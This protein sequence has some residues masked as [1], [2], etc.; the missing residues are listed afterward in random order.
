MN[1]ILSNV[2]RRLK[3]AGITSLE[4]FHCDHFEPWADNTGNGNYIPNYQIEP[5]EL[6]RDQKSL[7]D[8]FVEQSDHAWYAKKLTLFY[9]PALLALHQDE[10][11]TNSLLKNDKD[12]IGFV[13]YDEEIQRLMTNALSKVSASTHEIQLHLHHETFTNSD[14]SKSAITHQWLESQSSPVQD[15]DRLRLALDY[16]KSLIKNDLGVELK[17]W[18]FVHG[19]WALN[20]SDKSVCRISNELSILKKAGCFGD[21]TFPAGRKNTNPT[22][23]LLPFTCVPKNVDKCYDSINSSPLVISDNM[24]RT[25]DRFF[26][27]NSVLQHRGA[28]L[29]YYSKIVKD[30]FSDPEEAVFNWITQSPVFNNKIYLKTHAH[31]LATQ[32]WKGTENLVIPH[33]WP[34]IKESFNLMFDCLSSSG[35]D[36]N[37]RTVSEVYSDLM[38][39]D[40]VINNT[41]N[42]NNY[43]LADKPKL[44]QGESQISER[45]LKVEMDSLWKEK[46]VN[47]G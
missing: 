36:V 24:S 27:W 30:N 33:Q 37:C 47:L 19:K 45:V 10:D 23:I 1:T 16:T 8:S 2:A 20:A 35:I 40:V 11:S 13:Q 46:R 42:L 43:E 28:S 5:N 34:A 9:Q 39:A 26:I 18:A 14:Q 17:K 41:T 7:V 6:C 44:R 15:E 31:S 4:Y 38:N 32:Y 21:F 29:D 12:K 3:D 22:E 25:E